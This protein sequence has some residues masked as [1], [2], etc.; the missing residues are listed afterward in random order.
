L[1]VNVEG[2]V[3]C[4]G[5]GISDDGDRKFTWF[6]IA[7]F[8]GLLGV[9]TAG[10]FLCLDIWQGFFRVLLVFRNTLAEPGGSNGRV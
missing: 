5:G 10:S 7:T 6:Q 2:E 4:V 8:V 1:V 9:R 3:G